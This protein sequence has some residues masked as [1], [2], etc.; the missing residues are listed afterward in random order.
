MHVHYS[1]QRSVGRS[2]MLHTLN[3]VKPARQPARTESI[4]NLTDAGPF[5]PSL[6][7]WLL[8]C[9]QLLTF[10]QAGPIPS[11]EFDV[12]CM[13]NA[14]IGASKDLWLAVEHERVEGGV[15]KV[16]LLAKAHCSCAQSCSG[17]M[18][19]QLFNTT[20]DD[21]AILRN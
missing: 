4:H 16:L 3:E 2:A 15:N 8:A 20:G 13:C 14:S 12:I 1:G 18:L 9:H 17:T 11:T 7:A 10:Q 6:F 5:G 21:E 19:A